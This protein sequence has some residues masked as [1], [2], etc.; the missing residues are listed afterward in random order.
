MTIFIDSDGC[1]VVDITVKLST[2]AGVNCIIICNTSHAFNKPPAKT[3]T[4]SKGD[5]SVDF[6]LVN[7][8]KAGDIA[9][10]QDYALA[11]MVLARGGV[12]ISQNG[13]IYTND[14]IDALLMQRHAA[15]KIRASGGRLKG[16]SK[17]TSEQDKTFESALRSLLGIKSI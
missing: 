14:N 9:I 11:A 10:T 15:R 6:V 2:Q 13:L 17:R 8:I 4:V 1:P 12:P 7:M 5:D 16:P 3:I